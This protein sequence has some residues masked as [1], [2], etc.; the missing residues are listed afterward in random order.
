MAN[1]E[2]VSANK[3]GQL[4]PQQI[5]AFKSAYLWP[6]AGYLALGA[7]VG[8]VLLLMLS[9][10]IIEFLGDGEADWWIGLIVLFFPVLF[11]GVLLTAGLR[12][13][14]TWSRVNA[15]GALVAAEGRLVWLQNTYKGVIDGRQLSLHGAAELPPGAYRFFYLTG[16][17][18]IV[19]VERLSLN[20]TPNDTQDEIVRA[21]HEAL[22]FANEDLEANRSLRLSR[23][24]RGNLVLGVM[25]LVGFFGSFVLILTSGVGVVLSGGSLR[26]AVASGL[27][28][29]LCFAPILLGLVVVFVPSIAA[30]MRDALA[31]TVGSV[32]GPLKELTEVRGSGRSQRTYYYYV[33]EGQKFKVTPAALKASIEGMPYRLFYLPRSKKVLSIEPLP[34]SNIDEPSR[35]R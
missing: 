3:Q 35:P 1:S 6:G 21:L 32:V 28:P 34:E 12:R 5:D 9:G 26:L 11:G 30:D 4:T 17:N 8:G 25:Q 19:S 10:I 2:F 14:W 23:R 22:D 27:V 29:L 15:S 7:F 13:L 16:A 18:L 20:T 24:Q 31:G 33:V